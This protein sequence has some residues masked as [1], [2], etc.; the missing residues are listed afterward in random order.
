VDLGEDRGR[1]VGDALDRPEDRG[2]DIREGLEP[3]RRALRRRT[4]LTAGA[5]LGWVVS[6]LKHDRMISAD[7]RPVRDDADTLI[8]THGWTSH[9]RLMTTK[10]KRTYNLEPATVRRVRELTETYGV[11]ASQDAVIELAVDELDRR[12]RD[13][14]EADAWA[15]AAV[16]PDYRSEV[17]DVSAAFAGADAETWPR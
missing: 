16:D 8:D 13:A 14:R 9:H 1:Q 10:V 17:A 2:D 7:G 4:V 12:L 6:A 3:C 11:A 15:A 5:A